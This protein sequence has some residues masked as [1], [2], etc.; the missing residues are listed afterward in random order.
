VYQGSSK[1]PSK[2]SKSSSNLIFVSA[3]VFGIFQTT[4]SKAHLKAHLKMSKLVN[5]YFADNIHTF[6]FF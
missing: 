6:T 2:M 3:C 1:S 4:S 5:G